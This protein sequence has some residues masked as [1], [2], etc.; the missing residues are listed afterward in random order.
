MAT[1]QQNQGPSQQPMIPP[2]QT[3]LQGPQ[4]PPPMMGSPPGGGYYPGRFM[5]YLK[6]EQL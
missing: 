2:Q 6:K 1:L 3:N 4:G 5:D